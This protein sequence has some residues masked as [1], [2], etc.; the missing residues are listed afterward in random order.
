MAKTR[1]KPALVKRKNRVLLSLND[2][3]HKSLAQ[4]ALE[5]RLPIATFAKHLVLKQL[6]AVASKTT[7]SR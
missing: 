1:V 4:M 2:R 3:D 6:P 7:A 5:A